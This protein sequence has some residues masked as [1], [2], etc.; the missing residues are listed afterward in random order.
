VLSPKLAPNASRWQ[1]KRPPDQGLH[2]HE[3]HTKGS[4]PP[5][6]GR[7]L[8]GGGPGRTLYTRTVQERARS[9][10][11]LQL[12]HRLA[13]RGA[14]SP[15]PPIPRLSDPPTHPP[16]P[17]PTPARQLKV[18]ISSFWHRTPLDWPHW[19]KGQNVRIPDSGFSP[20]GGGQP[21]PPCVVSP[22]FLLSFPK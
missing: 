10:T 9:E 7:V 4:P 1:P 8:G 2:L 6:P 20:Q 16:C 3:V 5:T 15:R 19:L 12:A 21:S 22:L 18:H 14:P 13:A 17:A 11:I